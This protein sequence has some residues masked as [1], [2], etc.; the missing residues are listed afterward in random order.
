LPLLFIFL[1]HHSIVEAEAVIC[2]LR[3]MGDPERRAGMERF[4]IRT[5]SALGVSIPQLR[6]LAKELGHDH[7]LAASL[8][9]SGVHDAMILAT[10]VE[11]PGKVTAEQ[12]DAWTER[13][14]SWDLCDQ[15]CTNLYRLTPFAW[16]KTLEWCERDEEFVKRAGFTMMAV[17]AV[18]DH[19]VDHD[20]FLRLLQMIERHSTDDR[21][22]VRKAVNWALRQI[23][24]R[25]M[26][27]NSKAIESGDRILRKGDR[28]SR[29]I[30]TDA[31][32]ELRSDA[33][34]R[35]LQDREVK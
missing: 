35:R 30:A 28:S 10:M 6:S 25:D 3:E 23:G 17:L 32:K 22:F 2:R 16:K 18:H 9:K 4:G 12:M 31:L 26:Y 1:I 29:W 27:L 11:E 24:K 19:K 5:E 14:D 13:F 33:V 8:W 20:D 7:Q 21:N 15:C 34:Q